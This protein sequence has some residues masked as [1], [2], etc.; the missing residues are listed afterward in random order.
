MNRLSHAVGT[1]RDLFASESTIMSMP[2]RGRLYCPVC[3]DKSREKTVAVEVKPDGTR[4]AKC[5][6]CNDVLLVHSGD[7]D[8]QPPG[9]ES[10][11]L[12]DFGR[13]LFH[14]AVP[15]T[16]TIGESYLR[17]R[18]CV[19]P[20]GGDLRFHPS[21]K[22]PISKECLPA[23]VGLIT[24]V[25][26]G[27]AISLHRTWIHAD[28][29]KAAVT[30]PRMLLGGHQKTAGVIRLTGDPHPEVLGLAEGIETALSL[31]H[32]IPAVWSAIDAG[33]LA[34]LPVVPDVRQLIVARDNDKS[35]LNA[36]EAC[37]R[38]WADAGVDVRVT[39]QTENDLNDLL[40]GQQ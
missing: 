21:L 7:G 36:A 35:G 24:D 12:S 37:A 14:E 38:R 32:V 34:S 22:H 29:K 30:P 19:V 20:T 13:Q 10:R 6:R 23:L 28:G 17:A 2:K 40:K 4:Y 5:F 26:S 25:R 3:G 1:T 8:L 27:Q 18:R 11:V 33:N 15:L 39:N 31:A 16:G 9:P